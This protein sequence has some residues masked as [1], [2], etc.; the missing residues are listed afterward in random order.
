MNQR[1]RNSD[2]SEDKTLRRG[3]DFEGGPGTVSS[4]ERTSD[5]FQ[6]ATKGRVGD[7]EEARPLGGSSPELRRNLEKGGGVE[8]VGDRQ[9][10]N[11]RNKRAR[12]TH[13]IGGIK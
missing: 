8:G 12:Q 9:D 3:E 2:E 13:Q 1:K 11:D 5:R 7:M 4:I 6:I 10:R